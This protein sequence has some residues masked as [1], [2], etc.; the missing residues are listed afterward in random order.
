MK[1]TTLVH[2]HLDCFL[3]NFFFFKLIFF[4][5]LIRF[6]DKS[7]F[8]PQEQRLSETCFSVKNKRHIWCS[9][10]THRSAPLA[11]WAR[12]A[13]PSASLWRISKA[14]FSYYS[15]FLLLGQPWHSQITSTCEASVSADDSLCGLEEQR[16]KVCT[17]QF[18][19]SRELFV[20]YLQS[21]KTN[22]I[23]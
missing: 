17:H 6:I 4:I 9:G 20:F 23:I 18:H 11:Q 2:C 19:L 1:L 22:C 15:L 12:L 10:L 21:L 8:C 3:F 13:G 16:L 7:E 5:E 14:V